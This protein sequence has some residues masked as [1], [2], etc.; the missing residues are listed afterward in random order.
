ML[1]SSV[2]VGQLFST[3]SVAVLLLLV[4]PAPVR[5]QQPSVDLP[6][7]VF[8][9][10]VNRYCI[11]CHN[12]R[13]RT[14]GLTLVGVNASEVAARAPVLEKVM[15][16]LR[17]GEMPPAGR[18]GPDAATVTNLVAWLE[19]ELDQVAVEDP[20]PGAPAIH[21]LNRVEYG[22]AVRDLLGL[23]IDHARDLP[24]DDSGYG[25]DNIAD[26]LTVSPLHIEKYIAAARRISRLAVGTVTPRAVV[27]KYSPPPGTRDEAIDG[28]PLNVRGGILFQ[29]FFAFDAEYVFTVRVRGRRAPGLPPP[30]LD[31]RVDGVRTRLFDA[32]FDGQEANQGTRNFE[33]RLRLSAG[34][35]E[36]AA[37]FL[38][39]YAKTEG[40]EMRE[41]NGVSVD[42]L[43][44]GGPFTSSGPGE[45]ESRLP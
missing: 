33:F 5:S 36:I 38:T 26:V 43:L 42:Y 24:A 14:A 19:T 23:D 31:L 45:T 6:G 11:G 17:A 3:A 40:S 15:Q 8:E 13:T 30:K 34:E 16:K 20:N 22:N 7:E 1:D 25:F 29:H 37:G 10:T 28:L 12:D 18:P 2:V 9:S 4:H 39:E 35:H 41:L 21:R 44:V 27:E 32:D